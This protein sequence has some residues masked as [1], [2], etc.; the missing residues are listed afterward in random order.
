MSNHQQAWFENKE[1][2]YQVPNTFP[3][4]FQLPSTLSHGL[5]EYNLCRLELLGGHAKH[6]SSGKYKAILP[7][8]PKSKKKKKP[9]SLVYQGALMDGAALTRSLA[10]LDGVTD[11]AKLRQRVDEWSVLTHIALDLQP[12]CVT[13]P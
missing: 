5:P 4:L 1:E 3:A 2:F 8:D 9:P 12:L 13:H 7:L 6:L 11:M 10:L